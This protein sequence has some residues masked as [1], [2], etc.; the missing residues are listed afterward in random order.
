MHGVQ[1]N[2]CTFGVIEGPHG[3]LG[4]HVLSIL[5]HSYD[6]HDLN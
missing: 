5:V 1:F 2:I 4:I 6:V 3:L